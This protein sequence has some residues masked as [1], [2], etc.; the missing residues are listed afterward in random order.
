MN[1]SLTAELER[2]V[3]ER[4]HTGMYQ[5]ASEVVREG[6]RLLKE[7]DELRRIRMEELRRQI[8]IGVE[9]ADAGRVKP[10]DEAV[11]QRIKTRGRRRPAKKGSQ[12][13]DLP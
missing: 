7:N 12:A 11:V 10:F 6:L 13:I 1:I 8:A 3:A 2:F 5:T 4:V 9:H